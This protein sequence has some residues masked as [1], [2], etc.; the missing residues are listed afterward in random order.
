[1]VVVCRPFQWA[2]RADCVERRWIL[3]PGGADFE[4]YPSG[5]VE[6]KNEKAKCDS[7]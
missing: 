5:K 7:T 1:M 3:R 4:L 2:I 6:D